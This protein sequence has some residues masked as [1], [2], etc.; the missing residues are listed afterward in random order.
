MQ[1]NIHLFSHTRHISGTQY[2][3]GASGQQLPS[4]VPQ[5]YNISIIT[6]HIIGQS[7]NDKC[8]LY[9]AFYRCLCKFHLIPLPQP[10]EGK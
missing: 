5:I 4:W 1:L 9:G 2:P 6:G 8:L 3:R 10:Y 7:K